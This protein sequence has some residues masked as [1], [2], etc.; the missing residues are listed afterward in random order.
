MKTLVAYYSR[1]GNTKKVA[2]DLAKKLK[3]DVDELKDKKKMGFIG[4]WLKGT[5]HAMKEKPSE[6]IFSKSPEDYDLV[7]LGGP[8][9]AWNLI[10]PIRGYLT[11][12][13]KKI[14]KLAFFVTYGGNLGKNFEQVSNLKDTIAFMKLIDKDVK[15]GSYQKDLDEF[16][17]KLN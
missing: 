14:K 16:L 7:V 15:S 6:V 9:W 8:V 11:E 1:T 3:A 10:P 17:K 13:K 12:N 5:R 2:L 4:V